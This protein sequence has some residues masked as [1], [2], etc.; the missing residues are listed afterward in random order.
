[1]GRASCLALFLAYVYLHC[2]LNNEMFSAGHTIPL[3]FASHR[4]GKKSP[5]PLRA[6]LCRRTL[7]SHRRPD[8]QRTRQLSRCH[9]IAREAREKA[10]SPSF[11]RSRKRP[12]F[13]QSP[14]RRT[15]LGRSLSDS[16]AKKKESTRPLLQKKKKEG[17][18]EEAVLNRVY[19]RIPIINPIDYIC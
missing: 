5:P 1:M 10:Q 8:D 18:H 17:F 2:Q 13:L 9:K 19:L 7:G 6:A 12:S 16:P 15:V 14:L 3:L 4:G 11:S